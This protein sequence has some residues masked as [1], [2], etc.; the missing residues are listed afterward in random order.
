MII[1]QCENRLHSSKT[2]RIGPVLPSAA[3]VVDAGATEE[4]G[5]RAG[6]TVPSPRTLLAIAWDAETD[7]TTGAEAGSTT[8][9]WVAKTSSRRRT[10]GGIEA[11]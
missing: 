5:Q 3:N 6:A 4:K 8:R 2:T 1:A 10:A 9:G 11:A 7:S